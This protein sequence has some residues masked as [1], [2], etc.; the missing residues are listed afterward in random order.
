MAEAVYRS[1]GAF[2][3]FFLLQDTPGNFFEWEHGLFGANR[4]V[5]QLKRITSRNGITVSDCIED[6]SRQF[7]SGGVHP[8]LYSN[9][10]MP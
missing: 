5:T 9:R 1:S 6:A 3:L 2:R 10:F 8:Q 7:C 4:P